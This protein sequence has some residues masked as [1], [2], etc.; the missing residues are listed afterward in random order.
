MAVFGMIAGIGTAGDSDNDF[1]GAR[2]ILYNPE[3]YNVVAID[4]VYDIEGSG[5][6]KFSYF[7]PAYMNLEGH[8][9]KNG[10]SDVTAALISILMDRY[11]VK[12]NTQDSK[13]LTKR[14]AE[15]P[16]TPQEAM[17]QT[18]GNRFPVT[19]L[20]ERLSQIDNDPSFYDQVYTGDLVFKNGKVEFVPTTEPVIRKYPLKDKDGSWRGSIEIYEMP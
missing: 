3:G 19:Q 13:S 8:Y 4:N 12:Y 6:K 17:L 10:N 16:I 5:R 20:S 7:F 9:D 11:R 1:S 18:R 15:L 14:V 2:E